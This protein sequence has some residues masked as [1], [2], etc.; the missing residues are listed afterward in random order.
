MNNN[1]NWFWEYSPKY[2][3][4]FQWGVFFVATIIMLAVMIFGCGIESFM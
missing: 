3:T 2:W 1:D 4:P